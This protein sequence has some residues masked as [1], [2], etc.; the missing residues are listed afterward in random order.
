MK[1]YYLIKVQAGSTPTLYVSVKNFH[2]LL[3]VCTEKGIIVSVY[4]TMML[5]SSPDYDGSRFNE[6]LNIVSNF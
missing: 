1:R 4:S 5:K 2:R 3:D 6:V